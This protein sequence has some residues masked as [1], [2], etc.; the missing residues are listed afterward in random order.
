MCVWLAM[1]KLAYFTIQAKEAIKQKRK[2]LSE[3]DL[4]FKLLDVQDEIPMAN[5]DITMNSVRQG[6]RHIHIILN[7]QCPYCASYFHKLT[8]LKES[9]HLLL[10]TPVNDVLAKNVALS[11][12][13]CYRHEG[14]QAAMNLLD[15]WFK[16]KNVN[17]MTTYHPDKETL[18]MWHA[19]QNYLKKINL[20][21]TPF[22]TLDTREV[23]KIYSI[24]DLYYLI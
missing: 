6:N 10:F 11:V 21:Y 7:P 15:M 18:N 13:A 8:K 17:L 16:E 22:I 24:E 20:S 4:F 19:Q 1:K 9:L 14:F 5:S 2:L 3:P 12:L 23:P